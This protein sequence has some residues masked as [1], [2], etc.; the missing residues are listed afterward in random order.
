MNW[1]ITID[2]AYDYVDYCVVFYCRAMLCINAA[3]AVMRCPSVCQSVRPAVTFMNSVKTRNRI[4][5]RF[6]P[7][8]SQTILVFF[9]TKH[10]GNIPTGTPLT[11][12]DV[13]CRWARQKSWLSTTNT[14]CAFAIDR[15]LLQHE[16]QPRPSTV[17]FTAQTATHQRVL[18]ITG[19]MDDH[20]EEKKT[21][22]NLFVRSGKSQAEV[23]NNGRLRSTYCTTEAITILTDRHEASRGL[24]ETAELGPLFV[25]RTTTI[26]Q[27]ST[28]SV[29]RQWMKTEIMHGTTQYFHTAR[30]CATA[31]H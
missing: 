18:F 10:H 3:Y 11:G 28:Q 13:E 8:G 1:L 23:T 25:S 2:Y 16:Q 15:R 31:Q 30:N 21:K 27:V 6:A 9:C 14:M 7:S 17:Q 24:S 20:D 12:G 4:H 22:H 29:T 5:R 26:Q 19:N